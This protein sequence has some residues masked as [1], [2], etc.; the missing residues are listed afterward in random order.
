MRVEWNPRRYQVVTL[1]TSAKPLMGLIVVLEMLKEVLI[2]E[3][4]LELVLHVT[5]SLFVW[6]LSD[7][8][9]F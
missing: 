5:M 4:L 2:H 1:R 9:I 8:I 3:T 7:L 6:S